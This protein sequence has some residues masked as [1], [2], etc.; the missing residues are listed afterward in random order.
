MVPG[1]RQEPVSEISAT[2][3]LR[4][5]RIALLV[6]PTDVSSIRR[7]MRISAC[8]WGGIYNPIIPVY[9]TRPKEWRE[10]YLSGME[11]ALGY[12]DFYEPEAFVEARKELLE[13]AGLSA[14][15]RGHRTDRRVV[16]LDELAMYQSHSNRWELEIGLGITNALRHI[17]QSEQRFT[18][19]DPRPAYSVRSHRGTSLVEAVFGSYPSDRPFQYIREAYE[20]VFQPL[21]MDPTPETWLKVYRQNG[22]TP[23]RLTGYQLR[24][25]SQSAYSAKFYIFDPES[26][27]DLIDLWNLRL[28]DRR[29]YPIPIGWL[30]DLADEVRSWITDDFRAA[31]ANPFARAMPSTTI[32]FSRSVDR[33]R[34][35]DLVKTLVTGLPPHSLSHK[36]FRTR[37][38]VRHS[39]EESVVREKP[40]RVTAKERRLNLEIRESEPRTVEFPGLSPDF[41][42]PVGRAHRARW[43]NVVSISSTSSHDI[44]TVFPFN[45]VDPTWPSLDYFNRQVVV[46]KE[47]WSFGQSHRDSTQRVKLL[48]HEEAILGFLSRHG[49]EACLS[50]PG[51]IGRQILENLGGLLGTHLIADPDTLTMLNEMAGGMRRRGEGEGEAEEVY[52]RRVRSE[53]RWKRHLDER[54]KR[55]PLPEVALDHFTKRKV[56][57]LG[58]STTCPRC[59]TANWHSLAAV[60]YSVGCE[61]CLE[62]YEF[63]QGALRPKNQHWSYRVIGPFS[64]PDY[65]RGSYG[66]LLALNVLGRV[67]LT[68]DPMAFSQGLTVRMDEGPP[69]EVDYVALTGKQVW[70]EWM[71]PELVIGEAKSFGQ[72]DL[73]KPRDLAQLRRVAMR[74][75][76]AILVIS[77]MRDEFTEGEKRSL[78][79]LVKWGRRLTERWTPSNPVILLTGVEIF[80][81]ISVGHTWERM[82]G[83]H[84]EFAE[85]RHWDSLR[86]LAQ[87]TQA[88][89]LDLPPFSEDVE[90]RL[91]QRGKQ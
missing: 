50:D 45:V 1:G 42:T 18:L 16:P 43:T 41:A 68:V 33:N 7:F 4:P 58:L 62:R 65:A 81:Q 11:T 3:R 29:V 32:E 34:Q 46:G 88:I 61:R 87:S 23:L 30:A 39:D 48:S 10:E 6:R 63:P 5:V 90:R 44:A 22:I 8:L 84:A 9:R 40:L 86:N 85:G 24:P 73:I 83:R 75:P 59:A 26:G 57:R 51:R 28:E 79:P 53:A 12:V 77:V 36:S 35:Q 14:L 27:P 76:E 71:R 70:G 69:C 89:H 54:R 64:T 52:D 60:D 47:G 66:S 49:V 91:A 80:H 38:W 2:I 17:Y 74:F 67:G 13:R 19:R 82:G 78:L 37:V 21:A 31:Q 55:R 20:E 25:E 72:G 56:L 15:I